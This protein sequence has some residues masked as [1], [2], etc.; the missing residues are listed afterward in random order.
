MCK[1][2]ILL[3][4]FTESALQKVIPL[5][6]IGAMFVSAAFLARQIPIM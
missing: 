2:V 1:L 6:T 5:T 3:T 4:N